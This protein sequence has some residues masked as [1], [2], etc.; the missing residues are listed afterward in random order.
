M[1]VINI[2]KAER[3]GA[4]LVIALAGMSGSGKTRTALEIAFGMT[5]GD[6]GKIGFLDTENRR[7]SLYADV[8]KDAGGVV[9]QFLI[10]DLEPPFTPDRYSQ[11][12]KAFQ[13]AGVEVLI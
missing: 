13:D 2:R 4:R 12:I 9:Q 8:L 5:G 1:S 11:A 6:A 7:G 3:A 10:G